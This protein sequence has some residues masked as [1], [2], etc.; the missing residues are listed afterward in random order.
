MKVMAAASAAAGSRRRV[1]AGRGVSSACA[2][3]GGVRQRQHERAD[4]VRLDSAAQVAR[5]VG[6]RAEGGVVSVGERFRFSRAK[7]R[8]VPLLCAAQRQ[9]ALAEVGPKTDEAALLRLCEVGED[10][11]GRPSRGQLRH[12]R[13]R[14]VRHRVARDDGALDAVGK[15]KRVE[16]LRR[17]AV[18]LVVAR[19]V[20]RPAPVLGAVHAAHDADVPCLSAEEIRLVADHLREVA[21]RGDEEKRE[22]RRVSAAQR[23]H[24]HSPP[25]PQLP[26]GVD[27]VEAD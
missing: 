7:G 9:A 23:V 4:V 8:K 12:Q 18:K 25:A 15:A 10:R 19:R 2:S 3:L 5:N 21:L 13:H 20:W 26:V 17:G 27:G 24:Q 16:L 14:H 6:V 22:R 1:A 11:V